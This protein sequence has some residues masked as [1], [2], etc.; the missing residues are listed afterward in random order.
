MGLSLREE[1]GAMDRPIRDII[2]GR[3]LVTALESTTVLEAARLM[4]EAKVGAILVMKKDRLAGIFT[5]RDALTRVIAVGR[6]PAHTRLS[7][8]MTAKPRAMAPD[9]PFGHALIAMHEHGFRHMPVVE[10]GKPIGVVS[11]RDARPP[12]LN[13]LE[14]D[15]ENRQH[16]AEI[17]G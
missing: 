14:H 3:K 17:L 4:K 8:V 7:T 16:I 9:K 1:E 15:L 5:E 6:D 12:E 2:R 10:S 11:M 13:S